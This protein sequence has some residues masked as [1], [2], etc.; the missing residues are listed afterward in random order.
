MLHVSPAW[1]HSYFWPLCNAYSVTPP[2]TCNPSLPSLNFHFLY[3]YHIL[4][5]SHAD[6]LLLCCKTR[7][8]LPR[9]EARTTRKI[10]ITKICHR[11]PI[12][13][14]VV[15]IWFLFYDASNFSSSYVR[16]FHIHTDWPSNGDMIIYYLLP[17]PSIDCFYHLYIQYGKLNH[18][19][20]NL[21]CA[22]S[23]VWKMIPATF[24]GM[25]LWYWSGVMH[26]VWP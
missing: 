1:D 18:S 26:L 12:K 5:G 11:G 21:Y 16:Y 23:D 14:V 8:V 9:L 3:Y 10:F 17:H 15:K 7:V 24:P 25:P 2:Q 13:R 19:I 22:S 20:A 4:Q 6:S